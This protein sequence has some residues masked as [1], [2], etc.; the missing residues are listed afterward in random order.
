MHTHTRACAQNIAHPF[1]RW[2]ICIARLGPPHLT[3]SAAPQKRFWRTAQQT[4][5]RVHARKCTLLHGGAWRPS[6]EPH[7]ARLGHQHLRGVRHAGVCGLQAAYNS[8][9]HSDHAH[10]LACQ[11]CAA[12]DLRGAARG[13]TFC[14][15][16][17]FCVCVCTFVS[18]CTLVSVCMRAVLGAYKAC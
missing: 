17:H 2:V 1:P 3:E 5:A 7:L 4:Q 10:G 18:V 12:G 15:C 8:G 16:A 13:S 14:V 9:L 6:H 11:P